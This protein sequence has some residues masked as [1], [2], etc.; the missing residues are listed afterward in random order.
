MTAHGVAALVCARCWGLWLDHAAAG[1]FPLGDA[2][3]APAEAL[4][5]PACHTAMRAWNV[6]GIVIDRCDVHGVW[7]DHAELDRVIERAHA[8]EP[9]KPVNT[10]T[11]HDTTGFVV[12]AIAAIVDIFT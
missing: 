7:F 6:R 9:S 8:P 1:S 3:A 10:D 5:C 11:S 2:A 4:P 12:E